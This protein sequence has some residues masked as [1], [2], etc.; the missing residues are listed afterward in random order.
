MALD[1]L[2]VP[3]VS[4]YVDVLTTLTHLCYICEEGHSKRERKVNTEQFCICNFSPLCLFHLNGPYCLYSFTDEH[5][6][7][8]EEIALGNISKVF[9]WGRGRNNCSYSGHV[10]SRYTGEHFISLHSVINWLDL[11]S[12]DV[13]DNHKSYI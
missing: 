4:I 13:W 10:P 2:C 12:S 7:I 9:I 8:W 6:C 3:V 1:S 5:I 11:V